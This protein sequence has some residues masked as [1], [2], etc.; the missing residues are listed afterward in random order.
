MTEKTANAQ[1]EPL[2]DSDE[3]VD[4]RGKRSPN[5]YPDLIAPKTLTV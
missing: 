1:A 4:E 3:A 2:E 5:G